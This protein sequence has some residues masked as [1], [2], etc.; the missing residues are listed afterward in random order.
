M[1]TMVFGNLGKVKRL[2]NIYTTQTQ[3]EI[4]RL[5]MHKTFTHLHKLDAR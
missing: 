3:T 4:Q 5:N 2:K 1:S